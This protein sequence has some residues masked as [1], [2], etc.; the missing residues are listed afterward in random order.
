MHKIVL[1]I[2]APLA[3]VLAFAPAVS[4]ADKPQIDTGDTAWLL[5]ATVPL[6]STPSRRRNSRRGSGVWV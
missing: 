4:A 1:R 6:A 2:G 5:V 3:C